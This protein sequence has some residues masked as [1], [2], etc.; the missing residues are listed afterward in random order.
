MNQRHKVYFLCA[1]MLLGAFAI[2]AGEKPKKPAPA[3]PAGEAHGPKQLALQPVGVAFG[4]GVEDPQRDIT[5]YEAA[6]LS[7]LNTQ[8]CISLQDHTQH[9]YL[10]FVHELHLER[11][12]VVPAF[13]EQHRPGTDQAP[14]AEHVVPDPT[15]ARQP[16][17][18][19]SVAKP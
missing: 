14:P 5:P 19:P 2:G 18:P 7:L 13:M 3:A 15:P 4:F 17:A 12:F 9:D 16:E 8:A 1:A 11:H 10:G 6:M